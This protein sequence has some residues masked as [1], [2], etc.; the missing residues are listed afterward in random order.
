MSRLV[1][2][3]ATHFEHFALAR[4][5]RAAAHEAVWLDQA[6]KVGKMRPQR[7]G[8]VQLAL[9][10]GARGAVEDEADEQPPST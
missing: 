8:E 1:L 7:F 4:R 10:E 6:V 9:A 5:E 3:A 2:P